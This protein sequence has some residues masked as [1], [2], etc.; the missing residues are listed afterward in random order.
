[1][2]L[3]QRLEQ[4]EKEVA[5]LRLIHEERPLSLTVNFDKISGSLRQLQAYLNGTGVRGGKTV[6]LLSSES[7]W[8]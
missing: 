3:E 7:P 8:D 4:L 2:T 1:M 5:E 6:T